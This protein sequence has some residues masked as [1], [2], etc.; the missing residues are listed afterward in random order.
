MGFISAF[1][2]YGSWFILTPMALL[3]VAT[4]GGYR[5]ESHGAH[6]QCHLCRG[7]MPFRTNLQVPLHCKWR[8][9]MLLNFALFTVYII[10]HLAFKTGCYVLSTLGIVS[11]LLLLL[12]S[13]WILYVLLV[14]LFCTD[15]PICHL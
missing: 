15:T 7:M 13:E 3:S 4:I 8:Q 5:C 11:S 12:S 10:Y 14:T 1:P 6:L 9:Y 2:S